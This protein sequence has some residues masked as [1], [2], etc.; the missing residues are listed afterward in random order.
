MVPISQCEVSTASDEP[1]AANKLPM[2]TNR[3]NSHRLNSHGSNGKPLQLSTLSDATALP[4][5]ARAADL[6]RHSWRQ[7]RRMTILLV[8]RNAYAAPAIANQAYVLE[9][10]SMSGAAAP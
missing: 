8:E 10:V 3:L 1:P 2:V 5:D 9:R 4:M 6:R 7:R